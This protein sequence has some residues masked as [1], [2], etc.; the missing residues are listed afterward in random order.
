[1][2]L[3]FGMGPKFTEVRFRDFQCKIFLRRLGLAFFLSRFWIS[4]IR[5]RDLLLVFF[6]M[7]SFATLSGCDLFHE[8]RPHPPAIALDQNFPDCFE[9]VAPTWSSF[10]EGEAKTE[11]IDDSWNCVRKVMDTFI[12]QTR[13]SDPKMYQREEL[14][15][16]INSSVMKEQPISKSLFAEV[17]HLKQIFLGG[18]PESMTR[19]EI[20]DFQ[21]ISFF[22]QSEMI[23]L[24]E[25][26]KIFRLKM[27]ASEITRTELNQARQNLVVSSERLGEF[28]LAR[29]V[30]YSFADLVRLIN[31]VDF[32]AK[33]DFLLEIPLLMELRGILSA[34]RADTIL[35]E[36]WPTLIENSAEFFLFFLSWHYELKDQNLF[37]EPAF[38]K[39]CELVEKLFVVIGRVAAN[40]DDQTIPFTDIFTLLDLLKEKFDFGIAPEK[41]AVFLPRV[42]QRFL[43]SS[44]KDQKSPSITGIDPHLLAQV[45]G[46]FARWTKVQKGIL[47]LESNEEGEKFL[48]LSRGFRPLIYDDSHMAVLRYDFG[49]HNPSSLTTLNWISLATSLFFD[50][51]ATGPNGS[52]R[53]PT[54][55]GQPEK[56]PCG[57]ETRD[58]I[59]CF[60]TEFKDLLVE[61]ELFYPSNDHQPLRT[62]VESAYLN[63]QSD[64][65]DLFE[66]NEMVEYLTYTISGIV[67]ARRSFK[68]AVQLCQSPPLD[69][70]QRHSLDLKCLKD[71]LQARQEIF[72]ANLPE[73]SNLFQSTNRPEWNDFFDTWLRIVGVTEKDR[74][75]PLIPYEK[76]EYMVFLLNYVETLLIR[77]DQDRS[78]FITKSEADQAYLVFKPLLQKMYPEL[79]DFFLHAGFDFLVAK[80]RQ[81]ENPWELMSWISSNEAKS[82]RS[83]RLK[84][85]QI[86]ENLL[87]EIGI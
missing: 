24:S 9:R 76:W 12:N 83:D 87:K 2:K 69:Y 51:Y 34:Q 73:L 6:T 18:N 32:Q 29:R 65:D 70:F 21:E 59:S 33:E 17:M 37:V 42:I 26:L 30:N 10:F 5:T 27:K 35:P 23:L 45:E 57:K 58:D 22:L 19:K 62:A 31:A 46:V 20:L 85:F 15:T 38:S 44:S 56:N 47:G 79:N 64:G 84:I 53:G 25:S 14:R 81:P 4:R 13:G 49:D 11:A 48:R 60:F 72:M 82:Y 28:L 75:S 36:E 78:S 39:M 54:I 40:H 61:L 16:F 66:Y 1:M 68:E 52:L 71:L 50:A 43:N 55:T 67:G 8:E 63:F 41:I 7:T 80:G 74:L 77:Y 3:D 86:F